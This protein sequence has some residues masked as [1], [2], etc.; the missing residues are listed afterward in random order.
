GPRPAVPAMLQQWRWLF[1]FLGYWGEEPSEHDGLNNQQRFLVLTIVPWVE[2]LVRNIFK[3]SPERFAAW[4]V[5]GYDVRLK[6]FVVLTDDQREYFRQMAR[7]ADEM[8]ADTYQEVRLFY[9]FSS[10]QATKKQ[11]NVHHEF[12]QGVLNW[13]NIN[14]FKEH[15]KIHNV[16]TVLA[17]AAG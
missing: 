11:V 13:E 5:Y 16:P 3:I 1:E 7:I 2:E 17:M 4:H 12:E 10:I 9:F 14:W 15:F 6:R 8:Y